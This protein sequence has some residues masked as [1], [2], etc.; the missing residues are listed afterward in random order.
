MIFT[1]LSQ[2]KISFNNLIGCS[3]QSN[4]LRNCLKF[5]NS[6]RSGGNT[7]SSGRAAVERYKKQPSITKIKQLIK[8]NHHFSF[9]NLMQKRF[10]IKSMDFI[11]QSLLK[12][13]G[14]ITIL[15]SIRFMF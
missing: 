13:N 4:D 7:N 6:M 10:G 3:S 1:S 14:P 15:K 11:V 5:L 8:P 9:S 12:A 2:G